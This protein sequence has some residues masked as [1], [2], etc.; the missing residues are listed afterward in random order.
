MMRLMRLTPLLAACM[1]FFLLLSGTAHA[2]AYPIKD[3]ALTRNKLYRTGELR[4]SSC[5]ERDIEANDVASA[6]RYLSAVFNC[7]NTSWGAH[8]KRA[9]MPFVKARIGFITK[10][11]RFCGDSWGKHTAGVYCP[12]ERR[13]LIILDDD[14]IGEP[15]DLFL[16]M[17][18][19]HEYAHHVQNVTGMDRAFERHP[20][21]N[22]K[23]LNEQ[24]RRNELQAQCLAG[25]F[26]GSVWTSLDRTSDDWEEL[27]DI[28]RES[29]DEWT[30]AG[31]HGKGRNIA[32]WL[33]KGFRTKSPAS[34]NTWTAPTTRVS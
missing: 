30:K 28:N 34:C 7:L 16:F 19:A 15:E 11:R 29:G 17:L 10:P 24:L 1:F 4:P 5:P 31:D 33:D 9:G 23:E 22:K 18:V 26:M 27:L 8:L 13:F 32:A 20:Y 14:T 21:R 12:E 3:S 2:T 6:K 25:V